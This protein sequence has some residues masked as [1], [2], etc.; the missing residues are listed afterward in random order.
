MTLTAGGCMKM[1]Y[2]R[3]LGCTAFLLVSLAGSASAGKHKFINF[4][5]PGAR[6]MA[7]A[8]IND[9]NVIAGYY[10]SQDQFNHGYVRAADGTI[11]SF[12]GPSA[13]NTWVTAIN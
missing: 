7:V 12:D 10:E 2:I 5:V 11:T 13:L 6:E 8:G 1:F 9:N 3:I 4:D